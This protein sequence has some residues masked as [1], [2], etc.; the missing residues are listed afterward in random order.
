M[1]VQLH[2]VVVPASTQATNLQTRTPAAAPAAAGMAAT[3]PQEKVTLSANPPSSEL[4]YAD[5]RSKATGGAADLEQI[6]ADSQQQVDEF[7]TFLRPLLEQQG[8]TLAKV[9]S[10]EQRL[11]VDAAT[12]EKAKAD[13]SADGEFGV[14]KVAERILNFAKT[15]MGGDA[16]KIE[17]YRAAIQQGFDEVQA[18]LGGTLPEISQQTHQ[19]IMD[20][21]DRW[22][23]NGIPDGAV[24]LASGQSGEAAESAAA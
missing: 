18:M 20:E 9:A 7:M 14:R 10:G 24:S 6:L 23:A 19:A 13:V 5:P 15:A 8:L 16:S 22:V 11:T 21:L 12:I 3:Q 4:T 17:T 1:S 2:S